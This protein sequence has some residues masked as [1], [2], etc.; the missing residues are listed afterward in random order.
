MDRNAIAKW[1]VLF[2]LS[3]WS[4]YQ[5]IPFSK[6]KLGLDLKGGCSFVVE[7]DSEQLE[8]T[9][10][11]EAKEL[12]DEQIK[13]RLPEEVRHAQAQAVEIIRRRVDSLGLAEPQIYPQ[14][15][16]R[17]VVQLPGLSEK[18]RER[19]LQLIKRAA[20]LEFA[21]VHPEN[22]K[23]VRAL[24]EKG[25][26][27]PGF[28]IA[29][30]TS[31][32]G[33]SSEVYVRDEKALSST[34]L[35]DEFW[36]ELA[37]F[38]A[39]P[40]YRFMLE[41]RIE[42]RDK[43][44][45]PYFVEQKPALKGDRIRSAS[46]DFDS[47]GRPYVSMRFDSRGTREFAR[48]TEEHAP[49]GIRNP[50]P[51]GKRFLAI[52]LDNRL[53]SAPFIKTPIYGGNAM[54]EGSFT[55]QE[56][57]DLMIVLRAGAMPAPIKVIDLRTVDPTLGKDTI[58]SGVRATLISCVL[59]VI[60]MLAYYWLAGLVANIGLLFNMVLLPLGMLITAGVFGIFSGVAATAG[61]SSVGLPVLTMPGIAGIAL[62]LGMVVDANVLIFER[63]REE[64]NIGKRFAAALEAGYNKAFITILDSNIT[65]IIS[66]II[67]FA[68]GTGA[69]RGYGITL[70]A[71]IMVSM[72]SALVVTK[73]IFDLLAR[74]T[75]ISQL[76]ML[77]II[78]PTKFD[79]ISKAKI[80]ITISLI[81]IFGSVGYSVWKGIN[82]PSSVL[83][84]EFTGGSALS[85]SFEKKADVE[86]IRSALSKA[87]I[88][89]ASI[90][91]QKLIDR[92][93]E[94]LQ[95]RIPQGYAEKAREALLAQFS[96]NGFQLLSEEDIGPQIGA[97]MFMKAL[98]AI[99]LSL[100]AM[101]VYISI[102]FRFAY[103]AGAV[104]ALLH[105][106]L[107]SAGLYCLAG[108]QIDMTIVAALLTIIGFS[109]NDTIV[110]FDRIRE[111]LK[112]MPG[113]PF[114]E[115]CNVSINETLARTIITS[116]TVF[117]AVI[118]LFIFGGGAIHDFAF[119]FI[120]G[121]IAGTYSTVFIATPV[122][123]ALYS[124]NKNATG[125][126]KKR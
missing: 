39:P 96:Q 3:V 43:F 102:R 26:A 70:T 5:I 58:Q 80:A 23:L 34:N 73:M 56:A 74:K 124:K 90:Q 84:T 40:R 113:L 76:K 118:V 54:I 22:N 81:V 68:F 61:A 86:D 125:S 44:Y 4:L 50:S 1:I 20:Y 9:L 77:N 112:F 115:I 14:K 19:A 28:K 48:V 79:F 71:G 94:T 41:E 75:S 121:I 51:E 53:R 98:W 99:G 117:I 7:V 63:I 114:K 104:V 6:I 110:I 78:K 95:I 16:S 72:Y 100:V 103:A 17:I 32:Y 12:T 66:A 47:V 25:I 62:T 108:K 87:G 82:N 46:V 106:V 64:Q 97:E 29:T 65:T 35:T 83:G 67:L 109:V 60:F 21:L 45:I 27:P 69:V 120:I 89:Q 59:V 88:A 91:Y 52:I 30:R 126:E 31:Q 57:Q 11:E 18:D 2:G 36:A 37:R 85:F 55:L 122:M 119:I 42:G 111:K 49:G 33:T 13:A 93:E 105:D 10:R 8:K 116:L 107:V 24:F 92:K 101:I 123:M 38:H 15:D